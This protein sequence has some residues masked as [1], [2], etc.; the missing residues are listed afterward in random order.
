MLYNMRYGADNGLTED[1]QLP[2]G[3]KNFPNGG[4]P[5]SVRRMLN[6]CGSAFGMP[7][8][9]IFTLKISR[10]ATHRQENLNV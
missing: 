8:M 7:K 1:C 5:T 3:E 2:L 9:R 10:D 6:L 4:L